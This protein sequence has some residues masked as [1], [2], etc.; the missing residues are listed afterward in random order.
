MNN[1]ISIMILNICSYA[2]KKIYISVTKQLLRNWKMSE[3]SRYINWVNCNVVFGD[4]YINNKNIWCCI[5]ENS[6][7]KVSD[8]LY[9]NTFIYFSL[10]IQN[11]LHLFFLHERSCLVTRR[12]LIIFGTA[13]ILFPGQPKYLYSQSRRCSTVYQKE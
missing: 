13:L 4:F 8:I 1:L 9:L 12:K 10:K 6:W 3:K 11:N 7:Y 2:I 5:L